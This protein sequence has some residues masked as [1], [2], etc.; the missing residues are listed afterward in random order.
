MKIEIVHNFDAHRLMADEAFRGAWAQLWDQCPWATTCQAHGFADAWYGAYREHYEPLLVLGR[1]DTGA[2]LAVLPLGKAIR[3]GRVVVAGAHQAEYQSCV[4]A[5][6]HGDTFMRLAMVAL[7]PLLASSGLALR[8]MQPSSPTAWLDDA[9]LQSRVTTKWH[10]RPLMRFD[11]GKEVEASLKK[12]GNKS[13]IRR[14]KK[15][16][17]VALVHIT[18]PAEFERLL[19][20]IIESYDLRRLA[21]DGVAPF[22][23]DP[24]KR[25]FHLSL[26]R[27]P[28][29]LHVTVLKVG[30]QVASAHLNAMGKRDGIVSLICHN[31]ALGSHSPGKIHVLMLAQ[32]LMKQGY[33]Q[34]DLTPGGDAYKERFA[35][36]WD[37]VREVSIFPTSAARQRAAFM[38]RA[39]GAIR[40]GLTK[41]GI[42]PAKAK[43]ASRE[44][45]SMGPLKAAQAVTRWATDW[46]ASRQVTNVYRWS[47]ASLANPNEYPLARRDT[48]KQLLDC[49]LS[50]L[51]ISQRQFVSSALRRIESGNHLYSVIDGQRLLH[52]GWLAHGPDPEG[53]AEVMPGLT[54]PSTSVVLFD[55]YSTATSPRRGPA[56]FIE[57]MLRHAVTIANG[58]PV[59][60]VS[61]SRGRIAEAVCRVPGMILERSITQTC[62]TGRRSIMLAQHAD[63]CLSTPI[64][65]SVPAVE[66]SDAQEE[67]AP[68]TPSLATSVVRQQGKRRTATA[69]EVVH[70]A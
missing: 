2:L 42:Q 54:V 34:L 1:S 64:P 18:D 10:R 6:E 26:M 62:H 31:A 38:L 35:T 57:H 9:S 43:A 20:T 24:C 44:V 22:Q 53:L 49:D 4:S 36:A 51:G 33:G 16:G 48:L 30:D 29:L 12:S 47:P 32:L 25:P 27:T 37:E 13:R 56:S 19:G 59:I 55:L 69:A 52:C 65:S 11:D 68:A 15:F 17:N 66:P 70:G 7:Q 63:N 28:G 5:P 3:G 21:I 60:V 8:Y 41:V 23:H 40:S 61:P 46:S 50:E 58:A 45:R 39:D 14:M 67:P